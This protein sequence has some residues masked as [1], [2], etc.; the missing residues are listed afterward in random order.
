M[1]VPPRFQWPEQ[2]GFGR[3]DWACVTSRNG[4]CPKTYDDGTEE[5]ISHWERMDDVPGILCAF[6][7][8]SCQKYES[9]A[10]W[11]Y[12]VGCPWLLVM[13]IAIS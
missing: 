13:T 12:T 4:P 10:G 9:E 7:R 5:V 2:L 6:T 1:A 8:M 3:T 11:F